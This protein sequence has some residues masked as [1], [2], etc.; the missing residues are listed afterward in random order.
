MERVPYTD[1][2]EGKEF[3]M[4]PDKNRS[5]V[6]GCFQDK[7]GTGSTDVSK[8][9]RKGKSGTKREEVTMKKVISLLLASA[10]I[11][12]LTACGGSNSGATSSA[13]ADGQTAAQTT[14]AADGA[15]QITIWQPSDKESVENWWVDRLAEWNAEHPDIQVNRDVKRRPTL[16]TD[17]SSTTFSLF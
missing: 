10:M 4:L 3:C 17:D 6:C 13:P 15:V 1:F 14:E 12:G 16:S 9:C 11:V 5:K 2:H 8:I 7:Y